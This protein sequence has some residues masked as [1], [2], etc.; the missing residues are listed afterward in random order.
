[1]QGR[2]RRF[3]ATV[4]HED[5]S[6]NQ[7]EELPVYAPDAEAAKRL[8]LTYILQVMKLTDF[9]LRLVGA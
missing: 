8:A 3:A 9:E 2:I 4:T 1:M 5:A 6:G 7:E